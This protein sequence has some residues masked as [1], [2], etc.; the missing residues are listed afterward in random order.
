MQLVVER[1]D[2]CSDIQ[3]IGTLSFLLSVY[4][5]EINVKLTL[6]FH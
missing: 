2:N 6:A 5:L 3:E 4:C 1:L